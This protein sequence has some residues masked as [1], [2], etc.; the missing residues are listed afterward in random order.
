MVR[1][2]GPDDSN[3][4]KSGRG[5]RQREG[6]PSGQEGRSHGVA[7]H[8]PRMAWHKPVTAK[9]GLAPCEKSE[10]DIVLTTMRTTKPHRREGP[11]LQRGRAGRDVTVHA[12]QSQP[13]RPDKSR[14]L[15]RRLYLAAKRSRNRLFHALFDRI[16]RPDVLWRAWEEVQANRG[17]AGVDGVR[18]EDVERDGVDAYLTGLAT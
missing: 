5:N 1:L 11:L 3:R 16:V 9:S 7:V 15:Q 10:G 6:E 17:R 4:W 12:R 13:H 14:H 2:E 18:I 8:T